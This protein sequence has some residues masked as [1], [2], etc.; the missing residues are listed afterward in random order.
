MHANGYERNV[1]RS[2]PLAPNFSFSTH[3]SIQGKKIVSTEDVYG[4]F[5]IHFRNMQLAVPF[6]KC[7]IF[8][9]TRLVRQ[10][11]L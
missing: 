5:T 9:L 11:L 7:L 1:R 2:E 10:L 8:K 4:K 6:V 3:S